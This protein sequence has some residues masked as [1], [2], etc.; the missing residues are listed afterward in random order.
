MRPRLPHGRYAFLLALLIALLVLLTALGRDP[1]AAT[2]EPVAEPI[3]A[4]VVVSEVVDALAVRAGYV[5]GEVEPIPAPE[6]DGVDPVVTDLSV[7]SGD[8][9]AELD[10]IAVV[11]GRPVIA[12]EE[13]FPMYR[14]ILPGDRGDDVEAMQH[15]LVR[16]GFLKSEPDGRFGRPTRG[17]FQA[18]AAAHGLDVV[19]G[20]SRDGR[21]RG[22]TIQK[23]QLAFVPGLP[24]RVVSADAGVGDRVGEALI[25]VEASPPELGFD[26]TSDVLALLEVGQRVLLSDPQAGLEAETTITEI[27]PDGRVLLDVPTELTTDD[28]GRNLR[29]VV[30]LHQWEPVLNVPLAAIVTGPDGSASV[31]VLVDGRVFDRPV[32]VRR[33]AVGRAVIDS[34]LE[35]GERVVVG[36]YR[37]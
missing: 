14:T 16:A 30:R 5:I 12:A 35:A 21:T 34:G 29:A 17:A 27:E 15:L 20:W 37:P 2:S 26:A 32:V 23:G 4:S 6:L 18:F 22:P 19:L 1:E 36:W 7:R 10:R 3:T 9:I 13:P 33:V 31:R 24:A 25:R 8:V 11:A 28:V